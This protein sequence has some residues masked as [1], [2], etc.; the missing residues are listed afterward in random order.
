MKT[1]LTTQGGLSFVGVMMGTALAAF[2]GTLFFTMAPSYFTFWQVKSAMDGLQQ[3]PELFDQ[4]A[5][6]IIKAV[7]DQLYIDD[8]RS[9]KAE[10]FTATKS[11]DG[12][13]ID[14]TIEYEDQVH[15]FLNVDALMHFNHTVIIKKS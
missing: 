7:T 14:L 5:R 3:K 12:E 13:G 6:G 2:F 11:A 15:I 4:G 1:R 10:D 9:I 8:V